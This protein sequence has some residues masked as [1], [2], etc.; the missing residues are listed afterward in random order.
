MMRNRKPAKLRP[1]EGGMMW[2]TPVAGLTSTDSAHDPKMDGDARPVIVHQLQ[3]LTDRLSRFSGELVR[4][5]K[6]MIDSFSVPARLLWGDREQSDGEV[7]TPV[8]DGG[9]ADGAPGVGVVQP[10][11]VGDTVEV[12]DVTAE[13]VDVYWFSG[14]VGFMVLTTHDSSWRIASCMKPVLGWLRWTD[15]RFFE[16]QNGAPVNGC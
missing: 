5:H 15:G 1:S 3:G 9:D 2:S 12:H 7:S 13:V 6:E 10:F 4:A 8:V 16:S 11:D 14:Q